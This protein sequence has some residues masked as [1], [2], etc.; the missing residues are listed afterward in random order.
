VTG[1]FPEAIR[2]A[3]TDVG[4]FA[5]ST[6]LGVVAFVVLVVMLIERDAFAASS[7]RATTVAALTALAIPLTVA[8]AM[9]LVIR[10]VV[11]AR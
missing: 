5:A 4:T 9:T 3:L 11:V 1:V 8:V 2:D 6:S 10:V 7:E